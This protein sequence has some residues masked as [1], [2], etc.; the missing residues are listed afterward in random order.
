MC[1]HECGCRWIPFSWTCR[2]SWAP[3]YGFLGPELR[4]P[5]RTQVYL[6]AEPSLQ[7]PFSFF[8]M[9]M[10][11]LSLSS[12]TPE[13]DIRFHCRWLWATIWLLGIEL[14]TPGRAASL[15][16][17][18]ISPA[19]HSVLYFPPHSPVHSWHLLVWVCLWEHFWKRL[20]SMLDLGPEIQATRLL[21][22]REIGC[23]R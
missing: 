10:S 7:L 16:H 20:I 17:W 15:N 4:S 6:T 1:A 11:R 18:A 5:R 23:N 8:L 9:Y 19:P 22:T 13:E 3:W 14:R 12:D 2:Q 21:S